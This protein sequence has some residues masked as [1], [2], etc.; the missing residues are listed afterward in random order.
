MSQNDRLYELAQIAWEFRKQNGFSKNLPDEV[1]RGGVELSDAGMSV[2]EIAKA[3]GVTKTAVGDWKKKYKT[4]NSAGF[5]E[6]SIV[7]ERPAI[8]IKLSGQVQGCRVEITGPDFSLLQRLLQ[9][10]GD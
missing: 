4:A 9:K 6:A 3:I 1:R 7:S 5:K 8:E 10:L 2:A